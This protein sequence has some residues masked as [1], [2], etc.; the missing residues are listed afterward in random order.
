MLQFNKID[1]IKNKEIE[2]EFVVSTYNKI[3]KNFSD[4]RYAVWNSVTE[5]INEIPI[6]SSVLEVGCGNGKN[7]ML[8]NDLNFDGCDISK[9][10][11]K[12]CKCKGLNVIE[13][14]NLN[15]PYNDNIYDYTLSVAVIH[16]LSTENKRLKSIKELIRVT[17]PGGKIFIEVWAFEQGKDSRIKF[18]HQDVI[19]P[20]KDKI[21]RKVIGNRFY[22]VFKIGELIDL[23]S[24]IT[25]VK[26]I[27]EFY[28]K[29]NWV[30]ILQKL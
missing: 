12:M 3:A 5:F 28:E 21:S 6:N 18:N 29:G 15:L 16:H 7:M 9:E 26:I 22:H 19:V 1:I 24:N 27:K 23:I 4:T 2:K 11:V 10:F 25:N 8:R 30:T 14:N 13:A 20:F 17:K